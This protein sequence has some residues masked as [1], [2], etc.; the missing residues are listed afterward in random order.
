MHVASFCPYKN[1][2]FNNNYSN[3]IVNENYN[4]SSYIDITT[5]FTFM[6]F[7]CLMCL[8]TKWKELITLVSS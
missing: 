7:F 6:L 5:V 8:I 3:I 4:Y 2:I 1:I